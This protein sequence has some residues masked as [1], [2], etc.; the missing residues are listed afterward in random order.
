MYTFLCTL[1][2]DDGC[3]IIDEP[4]RVVL[5]ISTYNTQIVAMAILSFISAV[6]VSQGDVILTSVISFPTSGPGTAFTTHPHLPPRLKKEKSHTSTLPLGLRNLFLAE[7][8]LTLFLPCA[9]CIGKHEFCSVG[10]NGIVT[11][12]GNK[13]TGFSLNLRVSQTE[14]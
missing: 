1:L 13:R 5:L 9:N 12:W 7:L 14:R 8:D 2:P 10:D 4:K 3:F 6:F 11:S